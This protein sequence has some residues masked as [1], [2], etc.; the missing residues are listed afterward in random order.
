MQQNRTDIDGPP[1]GFPK[2]R[3]DPRGTRPINAARCI[4]GNWIWIISSVVCDVA[5][6]QGGLETRFML[7]FFTDLFVAVQLVSEAGMGLENSC[8][9]CAKQLRVQGRFEF[10]RMLYNSLNTL[11]DPPLTRTRL[12]PRVSVGIGEN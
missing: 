12:C 9:F 7:I 10:K 3:V 2:Y 8:T 4:A 6:V 1:Y 11:A 5:A